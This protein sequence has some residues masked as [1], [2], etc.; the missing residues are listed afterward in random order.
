[1]ARGRVCVC[2]GMLPA[3]MIVAP[4]S[5]RPRREG[6]QRSRRNASKREGDGDAGEHLPSAC[7]QGAG[8]HFEPRVDACHGHFHGAHH[9]GKGDQPGGHRR[10]EP[11]EEEL[12]AQAL[13]QTGKRPV[14][15]EQAGGA[16]SR[17]RR[18]AAPRGRTRT[19]PAAL[20][21]AATS[22]PGHRPRLILWATQA[23]CRQRPHAA[24]G[25]GR[26]TLQAL[27]MRETLSLRDAQM[28]AGGGTRAKA[29][30]RRCSTALRRR[31]AVR[32]KGR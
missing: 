3:T 13:L 11:G 6:Q 32:P 19:Y 30:Q 26:N 25:R 21:R 29:H 24:R 2:P 1:M 17:S 5:P 14:A 9:Q 20:F 23:A 8:S 15:A 12:D 18:A 31:E 27:A 22:L 7:P 16:R 10:G 28:V 4:N